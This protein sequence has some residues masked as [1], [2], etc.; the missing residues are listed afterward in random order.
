LGVLKRRSHS[1]I[2]FFSRYDFPEPMKV[3]GGC[4]EVH[5]NQI[6]SATGGGASYKWLFPPEEPSWWMHLEEAI[7]G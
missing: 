6:S 7:L 4:F 1:F 3:K 5:S 2:G